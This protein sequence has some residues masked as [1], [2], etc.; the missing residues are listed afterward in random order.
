MQNKIYVVQALMAGFFFGTASIFIRFISGLD[1][2]TIGFYRLLIA[3][4][5]LLIAN[6]LLK[7]KKVALQGVS[8]WRVG[9]LGL[10]LG[11]HFAMFIY[12]VKVTTVINATVLVNTT[13][14]IA[15]II[16]CVRNRERPSNIA[17]FG[18]L[19][20]MTGIFIISALDI[21]FSL[22]NII[23]DFLSLSAA[24]L[25]AI[26]LVVGKPIREKSDVLSIMPVIYFIGCIALMILSLISGVFM[27]PTLDQWAPL[28]GL[29]IFP[30]TI[31]HTLHF[32]SMKALRPF[33]T[34]ILT[35]L[36][37]LTATVLAFII[38][39]EIP[40]PPFILGAAVV[41]VGIYLVIRA[42]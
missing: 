13:P 33:Q 17:T 2:I 5:I 26:Y 34:S 39:N 29:S 12:S 40:A 31:G 8:P 4:S 11:I 38:L 27:F 7:R 21:K 28:I 41:L 35:L 25:W 36:E 24:I 20:S 37:P 32:S 9:I 19:M 18:L 23:G 6:L 22:S 15:L 10:L 14:A 3:S 16:Y 30:T 1:A 42:L